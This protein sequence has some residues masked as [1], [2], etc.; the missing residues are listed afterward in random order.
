[1]NP[2]NLTIRPYDDHDE[3]AVV[4]LW[5]ICFPGDPPRNDPRRVIQRKRDVQPELFLVGLLDGKVVCTVIGGYDGYRGWVYH[6]ATA[7]EHQ[8]QGLG[9][10]MMNEIESKLAELGCSKLNLQVRSTNEAVVA[11]YEALGYEIEDRV[12]LG[13]PLAEVTRDPGA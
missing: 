1:M 10:R 5:R 4:E 11:F 7:P 12:S 8:R 3:A 13:K 6:L 9:R 2:S